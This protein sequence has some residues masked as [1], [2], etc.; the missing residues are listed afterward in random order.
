MV[1]EA[2]VTDGLSKMVVPMVLVKDSVIHILWWSQKAKTLFAL[3]LIQ[4]L[5][6]T[7]HS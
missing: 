2:K 7:L 4:F 1:L 6:R 5:E 3:T